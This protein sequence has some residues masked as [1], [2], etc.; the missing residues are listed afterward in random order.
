MTF[1]SN[2][3]A[4]RNITLD[5]LILLIHN[6]FLSFFLFSHFFFFPS[7]DGKLITLAMFQYAFL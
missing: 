4:F 6:I 5:I 1:A 3:R 2:L 7:Y